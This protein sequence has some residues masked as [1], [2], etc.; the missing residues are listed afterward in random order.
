[1]AHEVAH[2]LL[3]TG[4]GKSGLMRAKWRSAD[5]VEAVQGQLRF[6]ADEAAAI[7]H[8]LRPSAG[9]APSGVVATDVD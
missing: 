7:R 3:P 2:A 5:L 4:H 1:M 9:A 6:S 8:R